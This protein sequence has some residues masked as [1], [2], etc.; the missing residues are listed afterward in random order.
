MVWLTKWIRGNVENAR[1][2]IIT[3]R[4][5]LDE[6]IEKVY[7]GVSEKIY[8]TQSGEDLLTQLNEASPWL[9][10]SL[11]HKFGG[12]EEGDVDEYVKNLK[13]S[14]PTDFKAKGNILFL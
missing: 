2:L 8:R 9:L 14:I 3:D 6:Q 4:E 12:K 11:V 1:V 5:E 13:N 7:N 10:C